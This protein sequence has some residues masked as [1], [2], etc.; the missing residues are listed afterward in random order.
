MLLTFH[1]SKI[2]K[3][4]KKIKSCLKSSSVIAEIFRGLDSATLKGIPAQ[5][6]N[7]TR[8]YFNF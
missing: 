3:I 2:S 4:D 5:G 8:S 7:Y 1:K 6:R